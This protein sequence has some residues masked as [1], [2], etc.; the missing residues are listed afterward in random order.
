[1]Y[2]MIFPTWR[3]NKMAAGSCNSIAKKS[4]FFGYTLTLLHNKLT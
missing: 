3:M 1:M 2:K 4:A